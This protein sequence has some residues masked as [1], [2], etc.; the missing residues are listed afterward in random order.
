MSNTESKVVNFGYHEIIKALQDI[1]SK[2]LR[3][4]SQ[5]IH[6]FFDVAKDY[7]YQEKVNDI[8]RVGVIGLNIPEELIIACGAKPIWILGGSFDFANYADSLVARDTDPMIKSLLGMLMSNQFSSFMNIDLLVVPTSSDSMRKCAYLL[9]KQIDTFI[10]DIPPIKE[11]ESSNI[12]LR[13]Q[14]KAMT[15]KIC[16]LTG[17]KL[18]I[19]DLIDATNIVTEAKL[20]TK[21]FVNNYKKSNNLI[22]NSLYLLILNSYFMADD[23]KRWSLELASLNDEIEKSF[24]N[25]IT[26]TTEQTPHILLMGSTIFF[27]N[28]KIPILFDELGLN[29]SHF[30]VEMLSYLSTI[31]YVENMK[32]KNKI[33]ES[34]TDTYYESSTSQAFIN[35]KTSI[36]S[37]KTA[38]VH[39]KVDGVVYHVIRGQVSCDF[40]FDSI[41]N[42]FI[43]KDIPI[44]R[45]ETDYNYQDIEQ[46]RIR[47]EAF[48]E[49][50][51]AKYSYSFTKYNKMNQKE[52]EIA[53]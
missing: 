38:L 45:I 30:E 43:E 18:K 50:L 17:K 10:V 40:E 8:K 4:K 53:E 25:R 2:E 32:S 41:E 3:F 9:S 14:F 29:I 39:T 13:N 52:I 48:G 26:E 23:L 31:P 44:L 24:K 46:L 21:R 37:L 28:M 15:E 12:K 51:M 7:M 19:K 20:Q 16:E 6:Y 22:S 5:Y 36:D 42:F 27:P 47:L 1:K 34:I 11:H 35:N 49:M 33:I